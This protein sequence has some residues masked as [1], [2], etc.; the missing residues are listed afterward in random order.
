MSGMKEKPLKSTKFW[1]VVILA[2]LAGAI[3][4]LTY[5]QS[6]QVEGS[7]VRV[8]QDGEIVDT[9]SLEE[10]VCRRYESP[11]GGFNV[12]TVEDGKVSVTEADC[13]DQVCVHH[14]AT[15]VSGDPIVCLPNLLVVEVY[16]SAAEIDGVS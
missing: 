10:P 6:R 12:V 7:M 5:L 4:T 9:F 1:V 16:G 11:R 3:G 2:V 15:D 13:P 14:A 8:M